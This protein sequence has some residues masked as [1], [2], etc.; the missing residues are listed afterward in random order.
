[1]APHPHRA[2]LFGF[3]PVFHY[4]VPQPSH[5]PDTGHLFKEIIGRRPEESQP[6]GN[7]VDV[8]SPAGHFGEDGDAGGE[9]DGHFGDAGSAPF[10][11]VI[12]V[13]GDV[14]PPGHVL[15]D[16]LYVVALY[17]EIV[18][19]WDI[20][21]SAAH[22]TFHDKIVLHAA[23]EL[24]P[25]DAP[26][27]GHNQ[28][29]REG[30]G[31]VLRV[32]GDDGSAHCIDG[33]VL[34]DCLHVFNAVDRH[35]DGGHLPPG[36]RFVGVK[37]LHRGQVKRPVGAGSPVFKESFHAPVAFFRGTGA[38]ELAHGEGTAAVNVRVDAAGVRLFSGKA[39]IL[40]VV[41]PGV[42][43]GGVYQ[44]PGY[45]RTEHGVGRDRPVLPV[46][47]P[48]D[49]VL[50]A[51]KLPGYVFYRFRTVERNALTGGCFFL[52]NLPGRFLAAHSFT[53]SGPVRRR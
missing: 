49:G 4:L 43:E 24:A 29:H 9:G 2:R 34:A 19:G 47:L 10:P 42:I 6:L 40:L 7:P 35:A 14:V 31:R 13:Q 3:K 12:S 36:F 52:K 32:V 17:P 53:L 37:H 39:Q 1:M 50:P 27:F 22:Q 5:R 25:G 46:L 16:E 21:G 45:F 41:K 44:V 11:Q 28:V 26:A 30:D 33:N 15:P 8:V 20:F 48:D 51:I 38:E 18:P 23:G